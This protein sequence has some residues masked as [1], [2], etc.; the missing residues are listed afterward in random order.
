MRGARAGLF[1]SLPP[2]KSPLAR[3]QRWPFDRAGAGLTPGTKLVAR[4]TTAEGLR[5]AILTRHFNLPFDLATATT[6]QI[7]YGLAKTAEQRGLTA[8][9]LQ[10]VAKIACLK[11]KQ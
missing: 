4:L 7:R 10:Q 9:F 1:K 8:A 5:I 2:A 6:E 11:K 3:D